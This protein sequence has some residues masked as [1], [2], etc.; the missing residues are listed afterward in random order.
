M[1]TVSPDLHKMLHVL[2]SKAV[3]QEGYNKREWQDLDGLLH[4]RESLLDHEPPY[5][6]LFSTYDELERL[7]GLV[8]DAIGGAPD[9]PML[10]SLRT[11]L[12]EAQHQL[13]RPIR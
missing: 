12:R 2:W 4:D 6:Q 1:N 8:D 10:N 3:H 7:A 13:R 11:Q 5:A 9:W